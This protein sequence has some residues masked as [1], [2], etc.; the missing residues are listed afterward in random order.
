MKYDT[1][2]YRSITLAPLGDGFFGEKP[3]TTGQIALYS[4]LAEF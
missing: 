1:Y 3:R 2:W 4:I